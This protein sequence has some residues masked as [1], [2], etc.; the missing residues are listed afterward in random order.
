MTHRIRFA[1]ASVRIATKLW[2]GI[3][4]IL[5]CSALAIGSLWLSMAN[6][7]TRFT[8]FIEHDQTR[9][10][11]YSGMYA[12]GLQ[13]GQALRNI[14]L[15]P[16]N[17]TA[18]D[19]LEQARAEFRVLLEQ[20]RTVLTAA[21]P[22]H[23]GLEQIAALFTQQTALHQRILSTLQGG[24]AGAAR[25]LLNSEE[26][27][28]WR[29][30]KTRL[31]DSGRDFKVQATASSQAVA[32]MVDQAEQWALIG[33]VVGLICCVLL[34]QALTATIVQPLKQAIAV[35]EHIADGHLNH[36]LSVFGRDETSQLLHALE[37]MQ[38]ALRRF[39]TDVTQAAT[40]V[41]AAADE[42]TQVTAETAHGAVDQLNRSDQV[43]TAMTEMS[44]T[45]AEVAR[46]A[47]QAAAA[48]QAA[49]QDA[50]SGL[51]VVRTATEAIRM[52]ANAVEQG[53]TEMR[54]LAEQSLQIG[55]VV[56]VI[57]SIAEQTNLLALNAAI[58]AARAGEQGRGFAVVAAEVRTLASRT[59]L[60]TDEIQ[61]MIER[62]QIGS[63]QAEARVLA[64]HHQAQVSVE[65]AE[66]VAA[67]LDAIAHSVGQL[68]AMTAQI[69]SAA[70]QQS[71]VAED[72]NDNMHQIT[73]VAQFTS[74]SAQR[75]AV[76]AG[77]LSGLAAQLR[78]VVQRYR[79]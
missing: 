39:V 51:D 57:R 40:Q 59:Q 61:S 75:T 20:A 21:D 69:A 17:P 76:A 71:A 73:Q 4:F 18:Y 62:L 78:A 9:A 77:Q 3:G 47:A 22:A 65:Q 35:A 52:L 44:A 16:S 2:V 74:Q 36:A 8:H 58:E 48:T 79:I 53:G 50:E 25:Q 28:I 23:A 67:S 32:A 13:I 27:Q 46:N 66:R 68:H 15:E 24:D 14:I 30:M 56:G 12:Q 41:G 42:L 10:E 63:Q 11:S 43:T 38:E 29:E 31:L 55:S 1:L 37:R 64:G 60:S 72:V 26:I 6:I 19:N 45:V 54:G 49:D 70:K 34:A 7:Q 33:G 5:C